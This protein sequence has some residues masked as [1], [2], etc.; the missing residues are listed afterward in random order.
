MISGSRED[1][2]C[3]IILMQSWGLLITHVP[4]V[5]LYGRAPAVANAIERGGR[6]SKEELEQ[7]APFLL[8]VLRLRTAN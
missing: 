2:F 4:R 8:Y 6:L 1:R 3:I 7:T 5:A